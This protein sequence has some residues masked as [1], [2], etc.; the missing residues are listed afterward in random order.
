VQV[1][2]AAIGTCLLQPIV[3][4]SGEL[5]RDAATA[6]ADV[7]VVRLLR[8]GRD[9]DWEPIVEAL[10]ERPPRVTIIE[11][12]VLV[13]NLRPTTRPT[14][15][16][17]DSLQQVRSAALAVVSAAPRLPTMQDVR[18]AWWHRDVAVFESGTW[19]IARLDAADIELARA[20]QF[21]E[22]DRRAIGLLRMLAARSRAVLAV[23]LPHHP[24]HPIP[25]SQQQALD[26][27][28]ESLRGAGIR[29]FT[30]PDVGTSGFLDRAHL[31][32]AGA[33]AIRAVLVVELA[34]LR[35]RPPSPVGGA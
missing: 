2:V 21:H 7:T 33:A 19:P 1:D 6:G 23:E 35:L 29:I 5:E 15:G 3:G 34:R 9:W 22:P 30:S 10:L 4:V 13:R 26:R 14:P 17:V 32:A 24:S 27:V 31:N 8:P 16:L 25:A 28:T 12:P 18:E 11:L 20:Q